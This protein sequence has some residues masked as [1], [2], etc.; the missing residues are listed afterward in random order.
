MS[1]VFCTQEG[2]YGFQIDCYVE[3]D[4]TAPSTTVLQSAAIIT[5]PIQ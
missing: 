5:V 1:I 4:T 3:Y 2:E